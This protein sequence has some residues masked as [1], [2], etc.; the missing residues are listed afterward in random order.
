MS[1]G[2]LADGRVRVAVI[3]IGV[4]KDGVHRFALGVVIT[5]AVNY[6][7]FPKALEMVVLH[8]FG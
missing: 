6:L 2:R 7:G 8:V 3:K 4:T 1:D 5:M